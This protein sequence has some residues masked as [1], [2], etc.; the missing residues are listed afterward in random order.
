MVYYILLLEITVLYRELKLDL[1]AGTMVGKTAGGAKSTCEVVLVRLV[2]CH[3]LP[4]II[5]QHRHLAK[6]KI[7]LWST[8]TKVFIYR[9]HSSVIVYYFSL[10]A[11]LE[12]SQERVDVDNYWRLL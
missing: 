2:I 6:Y 11:K 12:G 8:A 3:P 5:P 7:T 4:A 10:R 1:K 9:Q